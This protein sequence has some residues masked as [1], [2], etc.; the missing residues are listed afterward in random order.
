MRKL[1]GGMTA[2][3]GFAVATL[4]AW[5]LVRGP[6][7]NGPTLE[8]TP[9]LAALTAFLVGIVIFFRGMVR[10]AGVGARL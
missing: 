10:F 9:M 8:P 1:F 3:F 4:G 2:T 7:L 5:M 6:F